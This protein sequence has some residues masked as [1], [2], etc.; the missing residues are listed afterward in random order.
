[1]INSR[2]AWYVVLVFCVTVIGALRLHTIAHYNTYWSDDG[3]SHLRYV[4]V[5]AQEGRLPTM[6]ETI[7]AWHEPGMYAAYALWARLRPPVVSELDWLEGLSA[8]VSIGWFFAIL[9]LTRY[10]TG[11]RWIAL[12][13]AVFF[14][15]LIPVMKL[16]ASVNPE[17]LV[18]T[19][20]LIA[21]CLA[22]A[23]RIFDTSND[24][25]ESRRILLIA[26]WSIIVGL[27]LWV[28]LTAIL[29]VFVAV[30]CWLMLSL[31]HR[32]IRYVWRA[33]VCVSLIALLYSPWLL[34]KERQLGGGFSINAYE[35]ERQDILTSTGWDYVRRFESSVFSDQPYWSGGNFSVW[36]II[37]ADTFGDYYNLFTPVDHLNALTDTE[38][39]LIAN[40]RRTTPELVSTMIALN[41][42]GLGVFMFLILGTILWLSTNWTM[43]TAGAKLFLSILIV[44]GCAA[45]LY[46]MLRIPYLERGTLKIQFILFV[47]PIL[48]AL[49]LGGI[50]NILHYFNRTRALSIMLPIIVVLYIMAALPA[51]LLS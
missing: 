13:A 40:G 4:A 50:V 39:F 3:G 6:E 20:I 38:T 24:T 15:L 51:L 35:Q 46:N 2:T 16:S 8:L 30:P 48:G 36:S 42:I 17:L 47:V 34:Y 45:L 11:D 28:K 44:G 33:A 14:S 37:I 29:L 22:L 49:G 27:A 10:V 25:D 26:A 32:D 9:A 21:T 41:R 5:I 1:M 31:L 18:Q 23:W 12:S 43:S 19:L 7:V